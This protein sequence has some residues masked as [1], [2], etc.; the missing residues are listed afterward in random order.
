VFPDFIQRT[1]P[2][3]TTHAWARSPLLHGGEIEALSL[4]LELRAD[5]VLM[6]EAEGRA[7]AKSLSLATMGLLGVPLMARQRSLI[8]SLAPLLDRLDREARFWMAPALRAAIL[9]A[10]GELP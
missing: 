8:G 3:A 6:D 2:P 4:A 1:D 10:S 5:L 7:T 9:R